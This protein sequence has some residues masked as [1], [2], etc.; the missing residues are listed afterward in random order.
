MLLRIAH[1]IFILTLCVQ[2]LSSRTKEVTLLNTR[3]DELMKLLAHTERQGST[4]SSANN[5]GE[6]LHEMCEQIEN[7]KEENQ[8]VSAI[9]KHATKRIKNFSP[10]RTQLKEA[11]EVSLKKTEEN[12]RE[13]RLLKDFTQ[14]KYTPKKLTPRRE[15]H[16][17][18]KFS[19]PGGATSTSKNVTTPLTTPRRSKSLIEYD[20]SS[21]MTTP[22]KSV[23]SE[24]NTSSYIH[25]SHS[26]SIE[27]A[28]FR[29]CLHAA[30]RETEYWKGEAMRKSLS[31]MTPLHIP[32]RSFKAIS[33]LNQEGE[34]STTIFRSKDF[35]MIHESKEELR[36]AMHHLRMA[37]I[38]I[39]V[40]DIMKDTPLRIQYQAEQLKLNNALTKL[41]E[42]SKKAKLCIVRHGLM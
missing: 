24:E 34:I 1:L 25:S 16:N 38:S 28:Y 10:L 35:D 18:Y 14:T 3:G 30:K 19:S 9:F 20:T 22:G 42:A 37:K 13:I 32:H 39:K 33:A 15:S 41:E 23:I 6:N 26:L 17:E 11:M 31:N 7:L 5:D 12:E 40:P 21:K 29:P 8:M 36:L 4:S 2:T 27:A